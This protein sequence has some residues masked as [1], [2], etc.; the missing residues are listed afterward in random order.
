MAIGKLLGTDG[1]KNA[2]PLVIDARNITKIYGKKK[3][4][5][6]VALKNV[7][8]Q[9]AEGESV[10]IVGKSGSGKSTLMHVL[11]MLDQPTKGELYF[12]GEKIGKLNSRKLNKVRNR[13]LGF[14]FQQFFMNANDTVLN[15]VMLPLV[16]AGTKFGKRKRLAMEALHAVGLED[17]AKNKASALSGGQKQRV[18]IARALVNNPSVIFADE[19]TGNLDS[20]TGAM[21]EKT[22]FDLNRENGITLIV[23]THDEDIAKKCKR[24]VRIKDGEIELDTKK[25]VELKV[26]KDGKGRVELKAV[27]SRAEMKAVQGLTET[28]MKGKR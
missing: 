7:S 24:Q 23:V 22:L 17:K 16:I 5:K 15:N 6:F 9:I 18:C 28:K 8:L 2:K 13:E 20:T 10:A 26:G 1:L 3:Q 4:E 25:L 27:K 12:N 21:V 11:A 14:V 19:P